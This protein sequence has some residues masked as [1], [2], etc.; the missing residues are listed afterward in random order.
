MASAAKTEKL[1]R[2]VSFT[3]LKRLFSGVAVICFFVMIAAGVMAD[4]RWETITERCCLVMVLIMVINWIVVKVLASYE[5][6]NN[7]GKA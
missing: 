6:M 3:Y 5:E 7:S 4:N 2:K 1:V